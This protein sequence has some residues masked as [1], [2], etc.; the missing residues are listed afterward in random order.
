MH[1][2]GDSP[3]N[4][5]VNGDVE[6]FRTAQPFLFCLMSSSAKAAAN[7][8]HKSKSLRRLPFKPFEAHYAQRS[9]T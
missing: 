6:S 2:C 8:S 3:P 4:G 7:A 1:N 5:D 9:S